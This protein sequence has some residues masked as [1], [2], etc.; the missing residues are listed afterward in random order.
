MKQPPPHKWQTAVID[1]TL[2]GY[3]GLQS[4]RSARAGPAILAAP[5]D[6]EAGKP[7]ELRL[8][9]KLWLSLEEAAALTGFSESFLARNVEQGTIAAVKGGPHES[10][11][12]RRASLEAFEG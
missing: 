3:C 7:A 10:W 8:T 12:I 6:A 2:R 9:E 5:D 11:R 1:C 4:I